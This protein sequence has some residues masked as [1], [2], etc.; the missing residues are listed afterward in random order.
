MIPNI[1]EIFRMTEV[2]AKNV[3]NFT[4]GNEFGK[5]IWEG[6]TDLLSILEW[7]DLKFES[8]SEIVDFQKFSVTVY[9]DDNK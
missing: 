8:I 6:Y 2:R 3:K 1:A 7:N 4:I 5:I 9:P